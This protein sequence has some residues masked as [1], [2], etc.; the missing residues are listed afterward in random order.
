MKKYYVYVLSSGKNGTL[1]VGVTSNLARRMFEHQ[2]D[3]IPGFTQKYNVKML[4]H[5]EQYSTMYQ[6]I[7]REKKLKEWNRSWKIQLIE[8]NNL[9]WNDLSQNL[10]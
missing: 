9:E 7:T 5:V 4:V 3:L 2:Q 1:Y 10:L 8:Q 6:A